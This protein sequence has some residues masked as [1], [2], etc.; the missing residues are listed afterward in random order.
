MLMSLIRATSFQLLSSPFLGCVLGSCAAECV[1]CQSGKQACP[2]SSALSMCLL[3]SAHSPKHTLVPFT[4]KRFVCTLV[5][6]QR[7]REV[8][9]SKILLSEGHI[10]KYN[11]N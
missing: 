10:I 11:Y 8:L 1:V 2:P 5:E 3:D 7:H 9:F 4:H 6:E